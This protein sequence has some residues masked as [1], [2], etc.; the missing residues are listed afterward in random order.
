VNLSAV[1]AFAH[2]AGVDAP[3]TLLAVAV[4]AMLVA[5]LFPLS[6]NGVGVREGALVGVLVAS[7]VTPVHA[8]AMAVFLDVQS[9]PFAILGAALWVCRSHRWRLV[10][11]GGRTSAPLH[12]GDRR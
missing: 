1:E 5:G 10:A 4:P 11:P 12:A 3:W 8:G 7:G 9:V 2:S 6:V